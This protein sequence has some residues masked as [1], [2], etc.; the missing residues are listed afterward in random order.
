MSTSSGNSGVFVGVE[1]DIGVGVGVG[2]N[3]AHM[4]LP[5]HA[6]PRIGTPPPTQLPFTGGP[7][8]GRLSWQQSFGPNVGVPVADGVKVKV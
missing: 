3:V 8:A 4:P 5:V 6:A 2:V 1:V 7:Q